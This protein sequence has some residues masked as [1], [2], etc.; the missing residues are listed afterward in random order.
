VHYKAKFHYRTRT[1][2][3]AAFS[4]ADH[5]ALMDLDTFE[6]TDTISFKGDNNDIKSIYYGQTEHKVNHELV[7]CFRLFQTRI[8][9]LSQ[10]IK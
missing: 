10:L 9:P 4:F 3:S 7:Q 6:I 2:H 5:V 1:G 8:G